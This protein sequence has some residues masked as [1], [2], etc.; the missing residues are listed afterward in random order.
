MKATRFHRPFNPLSRRCPDVAFDHG[1]FNEGSFLAC[2]ENLPEAIVTLDTNPFTVGR[3]P[4]RPGLRALVLRA[5]AARVS[6]TQLPRVFMT[7]V[8]EDAAA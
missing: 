7:V 1:F 3:T 5:D 6:G 8:P 2:I 4:H